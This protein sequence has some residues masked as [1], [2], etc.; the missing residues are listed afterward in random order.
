MF[1]KLRFW[2]IQL[3][4]KKFVTDSDVSGWELGRVLIE[5]INFTEKL[6]ECYSHVL[7]NSEKKV[8][9]DPK[10]VIGGR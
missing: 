1:Y 6:I 8:L 3:R 10:R 7:P 9:C 5:I 2:L 4:E